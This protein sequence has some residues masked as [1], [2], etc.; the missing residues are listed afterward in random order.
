MRWSKNAM[1]SA[2]SVSTSSKRY[3]SMSSA[4]LASSARSAKAISG[5]IIQNSAR[6]RLGVAVLG[7]E[8][9]AEGVDPAQRLAVGLDVELPRDG[10]VGLAAEEVLEK[11]GEPSSAPRGLSASS[12]ETRNISPAPSQSL[13]VMIGVWT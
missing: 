2:R 8:G 12:V 6:C 11:S 5:S 10:E 3:L 13:P 7:A 1:S 9:R 4:S